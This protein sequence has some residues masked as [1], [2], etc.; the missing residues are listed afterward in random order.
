MH[1]VPFFGYQSYFTKGSNHHLDFISLSLRD[2]I[3]TWVSEVHL[4]GILY[5]LG[6]WNILTPRPMNAWTYDSPNVYVHTRHHNHKLH[7]FI[8]MYSS[9]FY[10]YIHK[11]SWI[12]IINNYHRQ[13]H[14]HHYQNHHTPHQR[15]IS[16][17]SKYGILDDQSFLPS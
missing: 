7:H 17:F 1:G 6:Y 4:W 16:T 5:Q 9:S 15:N 14:H 12:I 13:N 10:T 11:P 8:Y 2:P 3:T